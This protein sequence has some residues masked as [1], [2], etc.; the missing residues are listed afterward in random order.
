MK[1]E[2][3]LVVQELMHWIYISEYSDREDVGFLISTKTTH[4]RS[5][6]A[7]SSRRR[8]R[9][10][11]AEPSKPIHE[12]DGRALSLLSLIFNVHMLIAAIKYQLQDLKRLA[13]G[14]YTV[15]LTFSWNSKEFL[16]SAELLWKK[17]TWTEE[18]KNSI[19]KV[20]F[21]KMEELKKY[22][23]F[24]RLLSGD[25]SFGRDM[26]EIKSRLANPGYDKIQEIEQQSRERKK[27]Y[28]VHPS[29]G[30]FDCSLLTFAKRTEELFQC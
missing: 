10:T 16:E 25:G 12:S 13:G 2:E 9:I 14:K 4:L 22:D 24:M 28:V 20:A 3:L 27:E 6:A 7:F 23:G 29:R 5:E 8:Y 26:I 1:T 21:D 11:T 30:S 17:V 18:L 19:T 15:A